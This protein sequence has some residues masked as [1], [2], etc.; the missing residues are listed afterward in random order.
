MQFVQSRM[1][2]PF[3][4]RGFEVVQADPQL[5]GQLLQVVENGLANWENL[6]FEEGVGS[7]IYNGLHLKP[8][9]IDWDPI[10]DVIH[11]KFRKMHEEWSGLKLFP[12]S[13]YGVRMYQNQSSLVMHEDKVIFFGIIQGARLFMSS[14]PMLPCPSRPCPSGLTFECPPASPCRSTHMSFLP[15]FISR[16]SMMM[17]RSP[18]PLTLKTT[19]ESCTQWPWRLDSSCFM[20][21]PSA[22][23]AG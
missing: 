5:F 6:P 16:T 17:T 14:M 3:T 1:T 18:G 12:T 22:C 9:M 11:R 20:K 7:A 15:F 13:I 2:P 21:A 8:K 23:M 10:W 4:K 19:M